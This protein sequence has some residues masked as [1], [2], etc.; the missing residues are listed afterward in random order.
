M[1]V[2]ILLCW[3]MTAEPEVVCPAINDETIQTTD[4]AII[5]QAIAPFPEESKT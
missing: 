2:M 3:M 1:E 5:L 4:D